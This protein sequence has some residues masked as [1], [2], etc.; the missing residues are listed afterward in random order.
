[1]PKALV[2]NNTNDRP[3]DAKLIFLVLGYLQYPEDEDEEI[4]E[5]KV[6]EIIEDRRD[7]FDYFKTNYEYLDLER[8]KVYTSSYKIE[9]EYHIDMSKYKSALE[10]IRSLQSVFIY[11]NFDIDELI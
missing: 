8:T 11:D 6:W 5:E 9:E 7:L 2:Y 3:R 4:E 10:M 1:M